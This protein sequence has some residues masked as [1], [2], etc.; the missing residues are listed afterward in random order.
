MPM[1]SLN[2]VFPIYFV[3]A[4]QQAHSSWHEVLVEALTAVH[5]Q[6][7][8]YLKTLKP[9]EFLPTQ[10]RIF[11]AFSMPI[12]SVRF[13]LVGEGPY[14]RAASATG[15]C[16]M[17]G[18]VDSLWS[19]AADGG[20]SKPVNRATSLRNFLKMLL[21]ADGVLSLENTGAQ[22]MA[23][24]ATRARQI[25]S[26]IIKTMSELQSNLID[27]GF[28]LLN[29]ALVFRPEVSP[30]RDALAWEPFLQVVLNSL[31]LHQQSHCKRSVEAQALTLILWG[32]IADK[33]LKIPS[34]QHLKIVRSEHP[35]NLSFIGNLHMQAL[36]SPLNLLQQP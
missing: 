29:A 13:V 4:L 26:G 19:E 7:P 2:P 25:D 12:E 20:L 24:V 18:Q 15:Y 32:Q 6:S 23:P 3:N 36:F 10:G 11:A 21:V 34:V 9:N 14:P 5:L 30:S 31:V 22:A 35:Y 27:C 16:F 33:L 28:L 17:D 1:T 8:G